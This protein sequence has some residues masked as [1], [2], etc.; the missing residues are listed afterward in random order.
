M[1]SV[2]PT[3]ERRK[4][5]RLKNN[6]PVKICQE[7]GDLIAETQDISRSGAYCHVD[8][9]I[10]P[11]TK[12]RVHLLLSSS[13]SGKKKPRKVSFDGVVV[14]SEPVLEGAGY[15]IAIFFSDISKRDADFITDYVSLHLNKSG[16]N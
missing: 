12:L 7:D 11:M 6:I 16:E 8:K 15:H 1:I 3:H 10:A 5:P 9:Y 2:K 13:E 4:D 14:R